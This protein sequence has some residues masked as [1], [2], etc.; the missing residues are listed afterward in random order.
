MSGWGS[1]WRELA[2]SRP[3]VVHHLLKESAEQWKG[4]GTASMEKHKSHPEGSGYGG[5]AWRKTRTWDV[6]PDHLGPIILR[7]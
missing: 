2:L 4:V 1:A 7:N 5:Q 6:A 3:Q